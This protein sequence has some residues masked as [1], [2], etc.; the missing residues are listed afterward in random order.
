MRILIIEDEHFAA[1]RVQSLIM[2]HLPDAVI[3]DVLDSIE[4]SVKWL[5]SH[6]MPNLIFMDIQLADGLSFTIFEKI[7]VSC[8]VVFTTA[9]DEYALNAFRVNSI[10]YLLKPLEEKSFR[11]AIEKYQ[12][13]FKS[14]LQ[15]IN[16]K[17]VTNQMFNSQEKY[18]KRFLIKTGQAYT[19]LDIQD[20][21]L[22][23]SEDSLSFA[24]K[25]ENKKLLIDKSMDKI[26]SDLDPTQYF[27][28]N[29]KFI[30]PLES[31]QKIHPYFNSRLKLEL[32]FKH[33][34]ELIVSRD[35]V[36]A[37]K[38]WLDM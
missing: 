22:I 21:K 1:K 16:W 8:P 2:D 10:D 18:K 14:N 28:I 6:V 27:R 5:S 13:F 19:Y 15:D 32:G 38:E 35:K 33:E 9:Y 17:K 37:F 20:I 23:Y 7:N 36:G 11:R 4:E 24:I 30:V 29:R 3:L 34:C 26:E 25:H 12:Q 31:I